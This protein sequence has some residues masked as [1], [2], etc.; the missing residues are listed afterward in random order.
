MR[1]GQHSAHSQTR[2]VQPNAQTISAM[3]A[4]SSQR[5]PALKGKPLTIDQAVG[6]RTDDAAPVLKTFLAGLDQ[7]IAAGPAGTRQAR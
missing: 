5:E 2:S 1:R 4:I 3:Q 7:L 6:Y